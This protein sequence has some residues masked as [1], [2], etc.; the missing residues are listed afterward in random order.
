MTINAKVTGTATTIPMGLTLAALVSLGITAALSAL[1]AW[2]ILGGAL[3]ENAVGYCAMGI[4]LLSSAAGALTAINRI[5]RLRFQMGA[6]S[7]AVYFICLIIITALFFGGIYDGVG[8]TALMILC[9]CGLVILL[10]NGGQNRAGCRRRKNR[11]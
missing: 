6:A 10:G 9:G 11:R 3:R 2:L 4:L 5:K 7:G 1:T 8:V